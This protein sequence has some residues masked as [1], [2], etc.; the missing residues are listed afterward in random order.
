MRVMI[1]GRHVQITDALRGYIE[2]RMKRLERYGAKLGD[3]Q[4]VVG[5]EKYRHTAEAIVTLNGTVIQGK[6]S[7]NEMYASI[8]QLLD[9]VSRQVRKRKE[10]L[11]SHK[12]GSGV[13]TASRRVQRPALIP[14][15]MKTV[16]VPLPTLTLAEAGSQ[17]GGPASSLLVFMNAAE[18]RIQVMRR[19]HNGGLELI[20]P[21]PAESGRT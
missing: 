21:Q 2:T 7:T 4:V 11:T 20:D 10:K 12:S 6:S 16:R 17:L 13:L 5:V 19:L 18:A 1:T 9:K 8:D 14:P 3:A 15:G